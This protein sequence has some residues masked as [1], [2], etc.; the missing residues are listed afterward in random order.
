MHIMLVFHLLVTV[1]SAALL[2]GRQEMSWRHFLRDGVRSAW[3]QYVYELYWACLPTGL[4][5]VI[6]REER[7]RSTA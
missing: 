7:E 1:R 3:L 2:T 4:G 6:A 5:C